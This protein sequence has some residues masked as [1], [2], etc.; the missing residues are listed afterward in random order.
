ML[1]VKTLHQMSP[2]MMKVI[3]S[4]ERKVKNF[5]VGRLNLKGY[6]KLLDL[7]NIQAQH[8][9]KSENEN[10]E[11]LDEIAKLSTNESKLHRKKILKCSVSLFCFTVR[12]SSRMGS[13]QYL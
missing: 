4:G 8:Q 7:N 1:R 2:Q 6:L 12:F 5:W 10:D 13:V 3:K 9:A 11:E